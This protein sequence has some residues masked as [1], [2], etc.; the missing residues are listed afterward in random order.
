LTE[1]APGAFAR[2][3]P[4]MQR[5]LDW[6]TASPLRVLTA[7]ALFASVGYLPLLLTWLPGALIVLLAL[8]GGPKS[9]DL[10]ASVVAGLTLG[11]CELEFVG[12]GPVAAAL[13]AIGL[14]VPPLLVG[15]L[16]ARGGTLSLAFQLAT[17][18]AVGLLVFVHLVLTDPPGIW[19][20]FVERL[21]AELDRFATALSRAG[22]DA[23]LSSSDLHEIA[24]AFVNWGVVAW[25][26]LLNT[27]V[28]AAV[29]LYSQGVQTQS[30]VLGP[31]FRSLQAGRTLAAVALLMTVLAMTLHWDFANDVQRLFI[32]AFVLQGLALV[33]A[34]REI[35]GFS[36]GWV[37]A[38]YAFLF[39]PL[40]ATLVEAALVVAGFLDNW[41]PL[42]ARL[43]A[44]A[45]RGTAR[46]G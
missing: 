42:R 33:H 2:R 7:A 29:G 43:A 35:L 16:L 11:W 37:F 40:A 17:L 3:L 15:R 26:L 44:I 27:V 34:A 23:R 14:I 20:P 5:F 13:I 31:A 1:R 22:S 9:L 10:T 30:A 28:A 39:V 6:L 36:G 18:S 19:Q 24:S 8:R 45:A 21:A 12:A 25:L 46:R 4:T 32:G 38:T 41:V